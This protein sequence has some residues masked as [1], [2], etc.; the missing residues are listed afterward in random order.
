MSA[1][2][3]LGTLIYFAA[4]AATITA[5]V[6]A[7]IISPTEVPIVTAAEL[8]KNASTGALTLRIPGGGATGTDSGATGEM[9][10]TATGML[11]NSI[12]FSTTDSAHLASL[13]EALAASGGSLDTNGILSGGQGVKLVITQVVQNDNGSGRVYAILVYN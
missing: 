5:T 8:L 6:S 10:L 1:P 3:L 13:V 2:L 9:T 12:V 4:Q 7:T 11:G